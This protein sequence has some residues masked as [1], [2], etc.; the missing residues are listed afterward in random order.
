MTDE[1]FNFFGCDHT[2]SAILNR[3]SF[4][5]T[6]LNWNPI[7]HY[8]E[9]Q[10]QPAKNSSCI[11]HAISGLKYLLPTQASMEM[12]IPKHSIGVYRELFFKYWQ[13]FGKDILAQGRFNRVSINYMGPSCSL[14]HIDVVSL[15]YHD[16]QQTVDQ[17]GRMESFL[18]NKMGKQ[19]WRITSFLH[20]FA[21]YVIKY[22]V[23]KTHLS[24]VNLQMLL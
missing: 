17:S 2:S 9:F 23:Q 7:I 12:H 16:W 11:L 3:Q 10:D 24:I 5:K 20:D 8:K 6:K 22:S 18:T 1:N 21:I 15:S 4:G 19:T 14:V 13:E